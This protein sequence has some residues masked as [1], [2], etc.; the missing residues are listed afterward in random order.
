[1]G[2]DGSARQQAT[3]YGR[4]LVC[5]A[6]IARDVGNPLTGPSGAATVFVPQKG[7]APGHIAS[8]SR[9]CAGCLRVRS[10]WPSLARSGSRDRGRRRGR[11]LRGQPHNQT[12]DGK[13]P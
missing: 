4:T 12:L 1:M 2:E 11:H 13:A 7:A 3:D 5:I 10:G 6:V 8:S 9:V